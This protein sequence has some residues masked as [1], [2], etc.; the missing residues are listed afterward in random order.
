M[1]TTVNFIDKMA[2]KYPQ[3]PVMNVKTRVMFIAPP[4]LQAQA[5]DTDLHPNGDI[6][7]IDNKTVLS[8]TAANGGVVPQAFE[9]HHFLADADI[10]DEVIKRAEEEIRIRRTRAKAAE[11]SAASVHGLD[12]AATEAEAIL[13]KLGFGDGAPAKDKKPAPKKRASKRK[14]KKQAA[15]QTEDDGSLAEAALAGAAIA[16]AML[17]DDYSTGGDYG[18]SFDSSFGD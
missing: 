17:D 5:F 8:Y 12:E 9:R 7:V 18:D 4:A 15:K 1:A 6:V 3:R 13:D 11:K 16:G 10:P 2:V 14:T